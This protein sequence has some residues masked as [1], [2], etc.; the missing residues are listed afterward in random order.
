MT[1]RWLWALAFVAATA[2]AAEVTVIR[3]KS[4]I[5]EDSIYYVFV[6]EQKRPVADLQN[7]ERVT[8]QVP[9]SARSVAIKCPVG[10]GTNYDESRL[11][12]DV[13]A[14]TP[15]F[16]VLTPQP[17]CVQMEVVD[18]AAGKSLASQTRNRLAGRPIEYDEPK[19]AAQSKATVT[20]AAAL[21]TVDSADRD[22]VAAATAAWVD[23]FNSRDPARISALYDAEAV[24]SDTNEFKPRVGAAAI[25]EYYKNAA[26]R[27]TQRVAL[28]ER[29]VR[30]LGD[31]AI[32]SGTMTFFEMRDG[33]ATT[34]PGRYS[35]T[36][37][38]RGG[39][40]LIVDHQAAI[41]R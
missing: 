39:K 28:G 33:N 18:A 16:V 10:L 32:D 27:P 36:Y 34:T 40:W 21:S 24:L 8:L 6:D 37:Q 25:G 11:D 2:S 17:T 35:L 19:V 23:A 3:P 9:A 20:S 22:K 13:K 7:G 26:K 38:K 15:V 12:L 30:L 41:P 14:N 4:Y 1:R 31:T 29:N 5:S